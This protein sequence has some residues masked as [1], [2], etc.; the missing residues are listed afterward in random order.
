MKKLLTI[1]TKKELMIIGFLFLCF[2]GGLALKYSGWKTPEQHDYSESDREFDQRL[3]TSFA[4][5]EKNNLTSEQK[6]KS[7][8]IKRFADSLITL[9]DKPDTKK[10]L[11][12]GRKINI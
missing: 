10:S 1:F 3:K 12:P 6:E 8:E 9:T 11:Q 5:L 7:E 2:A 4:E